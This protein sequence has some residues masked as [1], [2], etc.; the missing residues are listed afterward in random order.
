MSR[1]TIVILFLMTVLSSGIH[2]QKVNDFK[3]TV[4]SLQAR[5]KERTTVDAALKLKK[6]VPRDN[7]LD[8]Y[9]TNTFGDYPWRNSDLRWLRSTLKELLPQQWRARSVGNFYVGNNKLESYFMP[10]IDGSGKPLSAMFRTRDRRNHNPFIRKIG[11]QV[12]EKGMTG[13]TIALWQSHGS[14]FDETTQR[15]RWQRAPLFQT[16]EDMY[17]Q[18]YVLPFLIPMLENAGAYVMTPRERDPQVNEIIVDNDPS[19]TKGRGEGVRI[20]GQYSESGNWTSVEKGFMDYKASYTGRDNP[21]LAGTTRLT[22]C[23]PGARKAEARWTPDIPERGMYSVYI[24]YKTLPKSTDC[25]HYTVKHLGGESEFL[26]NQKMGGGTWIYLGTF[27]F[28]K[29]TEGCVILDNKMPEG[30]LGPENEVITADA[31]RFGG[32][33]GK[34]ARGTAEQDTTEFTVSG[35]P[36]FAEGAFYWMQWAGAD[37]TLL[38]LHEDDYTSD[39]ADRGAWVGWMSGGSRTNPK[40]EGLGIPVDLSFAFHSDAGVTPDDSIVG[41]LSIY[42]LLCEGSDK[43]P[44]GESRWQ[45][46]MYADFVQSQVVDDIR[47]CFNPSWSRRGLWDRS[48][49]EARTTTVPG[50][51]LEL[52]SHQNFGDMKYGH[53]PSFRFVVSR[54]VYKGMLKYLSSRYGC[55]YEVQPLPVGSFATSFRTAPVPG[56]AAQVRLSWTPVLDSLERTAAPKGYILQTRVDDGAFDNGEIIEF[57]SNGG[58]CFHDLT[59]KPG[60]IYSFRII[61]YNDGGR[62]FPSEVLSIG[63]PSRGKGKSVMVVNNF[64]RVSGPTWYDSPEQAGFMNELDA[65]VPYMR[66]LD[67]IGDQKEFRRD[68]LWEDDDNPGF[69]ASS[70]EY[71]GRIIPGNTFDFTVFHGKAMMNAGHPFHSVSSAVLMEGLVQD[72]GDYALDLICGKQVTTPVGSDLGMTKYQLFPQALQDALKD[73]TMGGGNLIVSGSYI[74]TDFWDK[75]FPI[76]SDP[77]YK[78]GT[79]E[80]AER[81]LGYKAMTNFATSGDLLWP[82]KNEDLDLTGRIGKVE[83]WKERNDRIY[84]VENPDGLLPASEKSHTF[85]RYTDTNISAAVCYQ[86]EGY[87]T[88]CLGFPLEV[89][90]SQDDINSIIEEILSFFD[91]QP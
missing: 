2:A 25:A 55:E 40:Q 62:S 18:S 41:T 28:D 89:L 59:I 6:V 79:A 69:G 74:G 76:E 21:F 85:L 4:D 64:T 90:K 24:S 51:I 65:G 36:S 12:F 78:S 68:L 45:N 53:D 5:L 91:R 42:T 48:Y 1:K 11:G 57:K 7:A 35:L 49:S 63:V 86:G 58:R 61:A 67:F 47:T 14:Y 31:V 66:S 23:Q 60:R 38:N 75:V 37:T 73:F 87:R 52:L 9:F 80:F 15:W 72:R 44:N 27:E 70:G 56:N 26:V 16:V 46:R 81:I 30:H 10:S 33:M 29:G 82:M 32:G 8:F 39:F 43:L 71:A 54:A 19:F 50:M 84:N 77:S 83:F 88:A 13:R 34:I 17:T 3:A 22:A 20:S